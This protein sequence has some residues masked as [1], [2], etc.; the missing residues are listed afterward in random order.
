MPAIST[1]HLRT[2]PVDATVSFYGFDSAGVPGTVGGAVGSR[3]QQI[4]FA[5]M[6]AAL[7]G[8]GFNPVQIG[9][10]ATVASST[11]TWK[12]TAIVI[13][14]TSNYGLVEI[15]LA[16]TRGV[17]L[18][19]WGQWRTLPTRAANSAVEQA[20][21]IPLT[22]AYS[23]DREVSQVIGR[24]SNDRILT[25]FTGGETGGLNYAVRAYSIA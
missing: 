1:R 15:D 3:D 21:R 25:A 7:S 6:M 24:R 18:V 2:D 22:R 20:H 19:S 14:A 11:A 12:D 10:E 8:A 16:E 5:L 17:Y 13:P 4:P 23:F 9:A